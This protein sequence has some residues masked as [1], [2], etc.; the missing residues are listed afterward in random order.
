[1]LPSPKGYCMVLL[2]AHKKWFK[3]EGLKTNVAMKKVKEALHKINKLVEG[4]EVHRLRVMLLGYYLYFIADSAEEEGIREA[5][6]KCIETLH[7]GFNRRKIQDVQK[8]TGLEKL[9]K[10]QFKEL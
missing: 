4:M 10:I 1:M 8:R 9:L 6:Y 2:L 3:M 5:S 7:Y